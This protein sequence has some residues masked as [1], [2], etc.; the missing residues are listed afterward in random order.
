MAL[1]GVSAA[2]HHHHHHKTIA[3]VD[4]V[5]TFGEGEGEKKGAWTPADSRKLFEKQRDEAAN[6]RFS[7]GNA[8]SKKLG[9]K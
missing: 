3:D 5:M 9:G 7:L 8:S 4:Y 6:I 2:R 1:L